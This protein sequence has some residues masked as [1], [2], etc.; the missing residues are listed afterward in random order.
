MKLLLTLAE[1]FEKQILS[2]SLGALFDMKTRVNL[3]Y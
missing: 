3:K 2:S 1:N